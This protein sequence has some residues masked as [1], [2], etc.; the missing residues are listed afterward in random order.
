MARLK[1]LRKGQKKNS[2]EAGNTAATATPAGESTPDTAEI[3]GATEEPNL[4]TAAIE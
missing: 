2:T 1:S 4:G 3:D